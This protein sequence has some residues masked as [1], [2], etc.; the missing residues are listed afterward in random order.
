MKRALKK[1]LL[2]I[3]F[4]LRFEKID[5]DTVIKEYLEKRN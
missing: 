3:R 1:I 4:F 2:K 5:K